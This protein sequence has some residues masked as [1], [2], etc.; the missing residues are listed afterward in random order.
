[1]TLVTVSRNVCRSPDMIIIVTKRRG[2]DQ[3][4][5]VAIARYTRRIKEPAVN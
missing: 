4:A 1:M 3:T 5:Y 2:Y